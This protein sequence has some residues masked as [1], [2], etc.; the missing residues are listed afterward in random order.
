MVKPS[1]TE[2]ESQGPVALVLGAGGTKG[3]AHVGVIK[4]LQESGVPVHLIVGASAGA[5]IGPLY[6]A[7]RDAAAMERIALSFT[8]LS[9]TEWFLRG[10]RITPD[11]G[12]LGRALWETYGRRAFQEMAVPFA[13]VA[14]DLETGGRLVLREGLVGPAVEA[15][16]RPPILG[17]PTRVEG[18]HLV[19]GGLQIAVPTDLAMEMGAAAVIA[20]N[21]GELFRLPP[22]IRP[23]AARWGR[24]L[25]R[26]SARP[27]GLDGQ[28]GLLAEMVSR[29]R[30]PG[31]RPQVEIR[32]DMRGITA[33]SPWHTRLAARRG[34][35][36][37]RRALPTIQRTLARLGAP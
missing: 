9:F 21:V 23:L 28:M 12:S 29:D 22:R 3:W 26:R 16:I 35:E 7:S 25:R 2:G 6:A 32:P 15:S 30:T 14:H 36:A 1:I 11:G 34:E 4:V 17:R 27:D 31:P 20:V 5:L 19:D 18:R 10:L 33:F 8:T 37:A 24:S 13:A